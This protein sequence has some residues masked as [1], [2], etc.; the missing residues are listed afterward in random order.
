[1]THADLLVGKRQEASLTSFP[2]HFFEIAQI[3]RFEKRASDNYVDGH[4]F[5]AKTATRIFRV[6][7][8]GDNDY[9]DLPFWVQMSVGGSAR[10]LTLDEIDR[11]PSWLVG[12]G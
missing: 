1:M 2:H 3:P 10:T 11:L 9:P 12:R 4:Y 5:I 7:L 8:S 6:M